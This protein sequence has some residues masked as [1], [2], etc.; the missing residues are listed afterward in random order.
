MRQYFI[1]IHEEL[2]SA[3]VHFSTQSATVAHST[4]SLIPAMLTVPRHDFAGDFNL[5]IACAV[6]GSFSGCNQRLFKCMW[7]PGGARHGIR[8]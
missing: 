4:M 2:L 3:D 5:V 1:Y 8:N 7:Q 6:L